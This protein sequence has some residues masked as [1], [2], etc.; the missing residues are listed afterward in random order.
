MKYHHNKLVLL[1]TLGVFLVSACTMAKL[2]ARLEAN[3][4]CKDILNPKTGALMPCPETDKSF[5]RSVGL[6]PAKPSPAAPVV[7]S[8]TATSAAIANSN[9]TAPQAITPNASGAIS[10]TATQGSV[11]SNTPAT[12]VQCKPQIHK[13][14]GGMLPCP[15]AD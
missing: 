4:Q 15:A 11:S 8:T 14:T 5:Y 10:K 12:Q 9:A 6:E 13:K 1:V 2:E 3:P 7:T